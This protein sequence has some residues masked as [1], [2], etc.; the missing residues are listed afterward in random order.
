[1]AGKLLDLKRKL[2]EATRRFEQSGDTEEKALLGADVRELEK[3]V[4]IA[5]NQEPDARDPPRPLRRLASDD[6]TR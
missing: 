3:Q 5:A 2:A 1:M 4:E 6:A